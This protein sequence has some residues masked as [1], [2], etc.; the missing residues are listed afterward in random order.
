MRYQT[1]VRKGI[2]TLKRRPDLETK[3]RSSEYCTNLIFGQGTGTS[4]CDILLLSSAL[5]LGTYRQDAIGINVKP[6]LNLRH[7]SWRWW[8]PI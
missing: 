4:D 3:L 1:V 2:P 5:V 8:D 6:D 7:T